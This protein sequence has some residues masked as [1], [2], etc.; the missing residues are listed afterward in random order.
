MTR[1]KFKG[2]PSRFRICPDCGEMH[3][4]SAW[5][6]NH[7]RPDEELCSP[8]VV[9]DC[10]EIKSMADG[11]MYDSK[12]RYRQ[13]LKRHGMVEV[14]NDIKA[15]M[16]HHTKVDKISKDDVGRALQK[17]KQGYKPKIHA[18]PVNRANDVAL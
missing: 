17:V 2:A 6:G 10:I 4:M 1:I 12:S 14:G 18:D 5:P 11:A 7:R 15:A 9:S 3:E 13:S 8:G 16:T